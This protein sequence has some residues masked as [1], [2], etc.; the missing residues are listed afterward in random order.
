MS[1]IVPILDA[2][3]HKKGLGFIP[4]TPLCSGT[5]LALTYPEHLG[6]ANGTDA[7]GCRLAVLHNDGPGIL[8]FSFGSTFHTICLHLVNLPF[9]F[10]A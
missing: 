4:T 2:L 7:L 5:T 9:L 8:H 6:P 1:I 3:A 10:E